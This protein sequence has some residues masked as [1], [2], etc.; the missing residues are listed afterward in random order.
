MIGVHVDRQHVSFQP[1]DA[2]VRRTVSSSAA[3]VS[4]SVRYIHMCG[5]ENS[6]SFDVLGLAQHRS[7]WPSPLPD[8][9]FWCLLMRHWVSYFFL[10]STSLHNPPPLICFGNRCER[11]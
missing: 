1:L 11:I 10:V 8:R 2:Y 3:V 5:R 7:L 9:W 4:P 6:S